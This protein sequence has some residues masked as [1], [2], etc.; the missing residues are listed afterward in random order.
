MMENS[1]VM[2]KVLNTM[3]SISGRKTNLGYAAVVLD[4]SIKKLEDKYNFLRD[5]EVKDIRFLEDI[6]SVSVM[7]TLDKLPPKKVGSAIQEIITTM[8]NTL[9]KDAGYFFIKELSRNL[10]DD[11]QNSIKYMGVDLSLL[12]LEHEV[13]ELEKRVMGSKKDK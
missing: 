6:D 4:S 3:V 11:Y 12:Q 9:G 13:N 1:K 7:S 10:E 2:E 5:V 8:N